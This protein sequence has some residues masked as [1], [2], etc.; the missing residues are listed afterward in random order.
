MQFFNSRAIAAY[1]LVFS[2]V[3]LMTG[4]G[5]HGQSS[6][7]KKAAVTVTQVQLFPSPSISLQPGEVV[8]MAAQALNA[9]GGQVFTQTIT[10]SSSNN[11][12]I[13]IGTLNGQ[14]LLCAGTWFDS[15]GN[16]NTSS[17]V[18][19]KPLALSSV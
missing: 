6:A 12:Q 2:L 17:A 3:V 15:L 13:Q 7:D 1:S 4:C 18:V 10:F 11:S 14:T 9:N 16:P 19:C 8:Q 5:G